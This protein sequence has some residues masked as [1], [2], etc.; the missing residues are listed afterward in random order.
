MTKKVSGFFQFF[1]FF[2]TTA[3]FLFFSLFYLSG[4]GRR[5][6]LGLQLL[7]NVDFVR[8]L[9]GLASFAVTHGNAQ[10]IC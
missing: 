7:M 9:S 4:V 2:S 3:F 8:L 10:G 6:H 1:S 5:V